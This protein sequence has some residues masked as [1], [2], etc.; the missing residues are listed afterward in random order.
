MANGTQKAIVLM[1]L[2][3]GA[4]LLLEESNK[5][6]AREYRV[7]N[8]GPIDPK[9]GNILGDL[10]GLLEGGL[11]A[12]LDGAPVIAPVSGLV[13]G[14]TNYTS[15]GGGAQGLLDVI[16]GLESGGDYNRVHGAIRGSDLPPKRLTTMTVAEV[17]A[18]QDRIDPKYNSEAA[19]AFQ[20][21]EDTL[22]GM[23][24]P[25]NAVFDKQLQDQAGYQLMVGRGYLKFKAGKI[26]ET[27]FAINL[28]REWAALPVPIDMQGHKRRVKAGES[29]YAGV[30]SN[31]SLTSVSGILG[32]IRAA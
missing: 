19:G 17:L 3:G 5:A 32:A 12:V 9:F 16:A 7:S 14:A 31:Q 24:L 25:A 18:W 2:A 26:T 13:G 6:I 4:A 21:M 8:N 20:I 29:Y 30:G 10:M 27:Q 1:A 11:P 28:S 15:V 22:R 23:G